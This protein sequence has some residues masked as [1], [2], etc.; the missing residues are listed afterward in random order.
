V[1]KFKNKNIIY[2][3]A[4]ALLLVL[5]SSFLPSFR[6]PILD[7]VKHPFS[8]LTFLRRE[9]GGLIFFHRNLLQSERLSREVDLLRL[10]L[11]AADEAYRENAR[12]K[13]LL[14]FKQKAPY[15]VVAARVVGRSAD[16]WSSVVIIDK[17]R[18]Q[19]LRRG[20][21]AI[22]HLGLAG[23]VV[24]VTEHTSKIMLINDPGI[25]V[26]AIVKRSRQ[27]GLVSGTLGSSLIM[28][29]LPKNSDIQVSD[30]VLTS[31]LTE[32]YPKGLL[33]GRVIEIGNEFSGL[34]LY[35]VIKPAVDLTAIEELL[36]I[37][38]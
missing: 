27:E 22:T 2:A 37:I 3:A 6:T 38:P 5:L 26:S 7:T 25:G 29:Y 19:G 33:I 16:N 32:S 24:E 15:R 23:K 21:T 13:D 30:L 12:L 8:I 36:I 1:F 31:G 14:A 10:K 34:S 35:A 18:Y 28:R 4:P 17:G 11:N 20:M 9:A